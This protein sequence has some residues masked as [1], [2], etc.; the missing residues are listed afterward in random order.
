MACNAALEKAD[1]FDHSLQNF[2]GWDAD[3]SIGIEIHC[4][5]QEVAEALAET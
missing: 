3:K 5:R 4:S 1:V 2:L